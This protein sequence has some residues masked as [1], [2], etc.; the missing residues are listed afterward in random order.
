MPK[1]LDP[2]AAAD[3]IRDDLS[4]HPLEPEQA[5]QVRFLE[6]V[7]SSLGLEHHPHHIHN[8]AVLLNKHDIALP[9]GKQYPK[10][11]T[12]KWDSSDHIANS[13][14][15]ADA[16]INQPQPAPPEPVVVA[17]NG[18]PFPDT[19]DQTDHQHARVDDA[20]V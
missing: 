20:D 4:V 6:Q 11:V 13:A 12:R 8:I 1:Q 9:G 10:H 7:C 17:D 18:E 19:G 3:A 15:E 2:Q 5:H 16:I 14:E